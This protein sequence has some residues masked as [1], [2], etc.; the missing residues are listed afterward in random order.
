MT[1]TVSQ[2][3]DARPTLVVFQGGVPD[4]ATP[5]ERF[6]VEAQIAATLDLLALAAGTGAFSGTILVTE[7][8]AL[9]QAALSDA[10]GWP[11]SMPF[12]V[13]RY[14]GDSFHFGETLR[15]ICLLHSL[16]RVV[17]IGGGAAPLAASMDLA[18]LALAVG[19]AGECVCSNNLYSADMVAFWP[20]SALARITPPTTDN[21]LAWLLHFKA[22]LPYAS[23]PRRLALQFDIDTPTDLATLWWAAQS[24][25]LQ[26]TPGARMAALLSQ[27]PSVMPLLA[28]RVQESYE[29]MSTRRAEVLV[30]GRVSSWVWRRLETNLPCQT[31]I[32]SEERGMRAGGREAR[33]EVHSLLGLLC[34]A[35]GTDGLVGALAEVCSAAFLDSRVLFAHRRLNVSRPDRFASDALLPAEVSDPWVREFTEAVATASVPVVLGGHSLVSGG[36]WALSERVRGSASAA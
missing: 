19:G 34:D 7:D 26:G 25:A 35:V 29:V 4:S 22:G 30:A 16:E 15:A 12:I 6:V 32:V 24:A 27:V 21:D 5:L 23:M 20:A 36:I 1:N 28:Q 17:Y 11:S 33:G 13:E 14:S 31:R 18:D 9:R 3:P 8:S 2:H 10:A